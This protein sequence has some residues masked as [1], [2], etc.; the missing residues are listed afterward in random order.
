MKTVSNLELIASQAKKIL[1]FIQNKKIILFD[2]PMGAGKTTLIKELCIQLGSKDHFSSPTYSIIN[3]YSYTTGKIYHFDLYRLN[4]EEELLD[5]GIEEYLESTHFCFF[6]WPQLVEDM[7]DVSFV[8]IEIKV[9][10][11]NRYL[12][13][14]H[15]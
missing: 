9:E 11:N 4:S 7:I 8:K 10:G 14:S 6:E 12:R 13:A 15:F 3:E 1:D 2:A 5:L